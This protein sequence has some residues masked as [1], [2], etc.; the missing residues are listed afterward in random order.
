[1]QRREQRSE[2]D[3]GGCSAM[4]LHRWLAAVFGC[5][6]AV[7]EQGRPPYDNNMEYPRDRGG[8]GGGGGGGGGM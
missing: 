4:N 2:P 6:Q 5:V 3:R 8:D 1:M 7:T